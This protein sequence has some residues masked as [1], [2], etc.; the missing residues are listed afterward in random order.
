[1]CDFNAQHALGT[2]SGPEQPLKRVPQNSQARRREGPVGLSQAADTA[3][4]SDRGTIGVQS[5]RAR[6][7]RGGASSK[8]D[9]YKVSQRHS[10]WRF[11]AP[12]VS[13][14]QRRPIRCAAE[15]PTL[16]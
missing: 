6:R 9:W 3:A 8:G 14:A 7:V 1:M 5:T 2:N 11:P 10:S 16:P 4:G 12:L 15:Q 13:F